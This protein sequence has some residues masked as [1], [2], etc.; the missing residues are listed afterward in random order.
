MRA[1]PQ[2]IVGWSLDRKDEKPS[3][4]AVQATTVRVHGSFSSSSVALREPPDGLWRLTEKSQEAASH[5]F[6]VAKADITSNMFD[7]LSGILNSRAGHLGPQAFDGTSRRF[8]GF[9][10]E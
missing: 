2:A 3:L 6:R 1:D 5:P 4:S 7:R 9:L 10:G 8:A